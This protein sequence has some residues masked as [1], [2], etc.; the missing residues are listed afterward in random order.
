[1]SPIKI[2]IVEDEGVLTIAL[3]RELQKLGYTVC[4]VAFSGEEAISMAEQERP[5]IVLMDIGLSGEMDGIEAAQAIRS[6]FG[7]A[8]IYMTGYANPKL[9]KRAEATKPLGYLMKPVDG[10]KIQKVIQA[11]ISEQYSVISEC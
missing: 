2:L 10:R 3:R 1:M 11:V 6:R 5:D 8:S 4:G 9:R 7:I